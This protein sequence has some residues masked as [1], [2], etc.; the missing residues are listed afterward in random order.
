MFRA[1]FSWRKAKQ[2]PPTYTALSMMIGVLRNIG[3]HPDDIIILAIDSPKGSWRRNYDANYKANRREK[4][5]SF[6]DI[7]WKKFFSDF[8]V[9]L[10]KVNIATPFH[11]ITIDFYEAD[12]IISVACRRFKDQKC[13]IVSSDS[14]YEQLLSYPNV[15]VFSPISKKYKHVKH[16]EKILQK[17]IKQERTDNLITPITNE[18]E[19]QIRLKIVDLTHL[20]GDVESEVNT[21]LSLVND[22]KCYDLTQLPFQSLRARFMDI[23][24]SSDPVEENPKKH[25]KK[26][27][28]QKLEL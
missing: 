10:D 25:P 2:I 16:P 5:E 18:Q 6:D 17:K 23:Y 22:E 28:I 26:L 4:R 13:I 11:S 15:R 12:D 24:N 20:P 1:I 21:H 27:V 8:R 3:C 19:Y 9:L 7:P 14:D